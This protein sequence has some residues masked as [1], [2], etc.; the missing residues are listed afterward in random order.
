MAAA[1]P[2]LVFVALSLITN[3]A[4]AVRTEH[5]AAVTIA[6]MP[7]VS[8][9]LVIKWGSLMGA[10]GATGATGMLALGDPKLTAAMLQQGA[11]Y[12]GHLALSQGAI[13]TGLIW[14]AI[15]ASVIDGKFRN[16][17]GFA[18]AAFLMASVGIIHSATLHWPDFSTVSL[19]YLIAAAFLFIYPIFHREEAIVP[20]AEPL[21]EAQPTPGE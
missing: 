1:A 7:H 16:A 9:F 4:H 19:G 20:E 6:M 3:T 18:F 2:V 8:S 12:E 10:L 15:V 5:M 14:G 13:L 11:H 17:G 21:V